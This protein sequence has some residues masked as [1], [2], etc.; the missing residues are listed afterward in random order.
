MLIN[1]L[2]MYRLA[3]QLMMVLQVKHLLKPIK[4]SFHLLRLRLCSCTNEQIVKSVS[5]ITCKLNTRTLLC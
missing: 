2:L 1:I 5:V 4:P 3:A